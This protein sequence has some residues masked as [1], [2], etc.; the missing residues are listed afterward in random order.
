MG[1]VPLSRQGRNK[2]L[3]EKW[4]TQPRQRNSTDDM[5]RVSAHHRAVP[6]FCRL[7]ERQPLLFIPTCHVGVSSIQRFP[8][9][10]HSLSSYQSLTREEIRVNYETDAA[11][12][13]GEVFDFQSL[14]CLT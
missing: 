10:F 4:T 3:L 8:S 5:A 12:D 7:L 6:I 1:L 14:V 11:E 2:Q 9:D 13:V